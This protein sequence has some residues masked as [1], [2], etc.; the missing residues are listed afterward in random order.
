MYILK[1]TFIYKNSYS[2]LYNVFRL[3]AR[4]QKRVLAVWKNIYEAENIYTSLEKYCLTK[5]HS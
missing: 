4:M 5:Q 2:L 1:T 3:A